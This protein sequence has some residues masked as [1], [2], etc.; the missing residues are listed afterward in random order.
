MHPRSKVS[1]D[2]KPP[3]STDACWDLEGRGFSPS[4]CSVSVADNGCEASVSI[5]HV[6]FLM[7]PL[8]FDGLGFPLALWLGSV[9]ECSERLSRSGKTVPLSWLALGANPVTSQESTFED[10]RH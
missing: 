3:R 5:Y 8:C 10:A 2:T 7:G 1:C 4:L 9:S 6:E